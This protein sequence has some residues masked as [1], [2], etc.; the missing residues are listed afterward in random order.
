MTTDGTAVDGNSAS[1]E[2][3]AH[4]QE[5]YD[6]M[7]M[8]A[9]SCKKTC[10]QVLQQP[11]SSSS[12][13]RDLCMKVKTATE[14][15]DATSLKSVEALLFKDGGVSGN[16]V[17]TQLCLVA[18]GLANLMKLETELKALARIA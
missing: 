6:G 10:V 11:A 8:K 17:K 15:I 5:A 4:L 16:E 3:M 9:R 12:S 18:R 13:S 7:H 1:Q 2:A 14:N